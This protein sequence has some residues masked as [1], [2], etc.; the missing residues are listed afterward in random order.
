LWGQINC[1]TF[2]RYHSLCHL[3]TARL[4]S[5]VPC[6]ILIEQSV[7]YITAQ[8]LYDRAN[9]YA[10]WY[11]MQEQSK[12]F[13]PTLTPQGFVNNP[14]VISAGQLLYRRNNP[15]QDIANDQ[16]KQA[17]QAMNRNPTPTQADIDAEMKNLANGKAPEPSL[18][19]KQI[20]E[21]SSVLNEVHTKEPSSKEY[22][23]SPD[24]A[25]QEK[26]FYDALNKLKEQLTGK[27]PLSVAD[28]YFEIE[29]AQGETLL[30]HKEF[31]Q[32]ISNCVS[33]IKRWMMEN[34][35][36]LN[37]NIAVHFAIQKFMSDTLQIG[38]LIPE[39]PKVPLTIHYP[40]YYDYNDYK[41]EKDYRSYHVT[42]GFATGNGQCHILPLMYACIA[43]G[44]GAK[45]YLS[46]VPIHSFI[47]YPDNTGA[48]HNYEVTSNW[49]M[50]DQWYKDYMQV[51][52][53]AEQKQI[54]LNKLDRKQIVAEAMLDLA[55]NYREKFGTADGK[56]MNECVD[57]AMNYF[58]NKEADIGGWLLKREVV[59]KKLDR[60]AYQNH[61]KTLQDAE[62]NPEAMELITQMNNLGNKIESLGYTEV[63]EKMYDEMVEESKAR[64]PQLLRK[65]NLEKRSL[66]TTIK[67]Q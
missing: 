15:A 35:L 52:S 36:D 17:S 27:R 32:E 3:K 60:I 18:N 2:A 40:F 5:Y 10:N 23:K 61:Y 67:Q 4:I 7:T 54:Y 33:F 63:D 28:A 19:E 41:A 50:S 30:N 16:A 49:Q 64:H 65:N 51:R 12:T 39:M 58:P 59:A 38:K 8:N 42:K 31:K 66:F 1:F 55:M 24:F 9:G 53:L 46:M 44:L 62:H 25:A 13:M 47:K 6:L 22:G 57:F 48:I 21:L 14:A 20:K 11:I 26:P 34:K 37:N 56:F 29:N 45:F 43:E